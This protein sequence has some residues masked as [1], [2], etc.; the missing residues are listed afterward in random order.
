MVSNLSTIGFEFEDDAAFQT[1]MQRLASEA[2]ERLACDAGDYAIWR[3]RTS[4]EIWFH[5]TGARD[6]AGALVDKDVIGLTPYFEGLSDV[7]IEVVDSYVRNGDNEFE[8]AFLAWVSPD[9]ES[10]LGAHQIVFDAVDFAAHCDRPMPFL[11]RARLSGFARDIRVLDDE[12]E[13]GQARAASRARAFMPL[14]LFQ[15][16]DTDDDADPVAPSS[17]ASLTGRIVEHSRLVNEESGGSFHWLLVQCGEAT[18]DV[19]ADPR[20]VPDDLTPGTL[21]QVGCLFFGRILA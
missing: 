2:F 8:G 19:V 6:A 21:V 9:E 7:P 16:R 10:G 13:E 11:A 14:G 3:S 17:H 18:F 12:D 4:A 20:L 15:E 1:V 5:I